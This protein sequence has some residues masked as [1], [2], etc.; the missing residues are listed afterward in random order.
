[1]SFRKATAA[2]AAALLLGSGLGLLS[3][4][5]AQAVT[6][7]DIAGT[8]SSQL[9][10]NACGN[11]GAGYYVSG[12]GQHSSCYGGTT[13]HAWCA[14]FAG[15][16]WAQNGVKNLGVLNDL[17]NSFQTY[18][19]N[20]QGGLSS[21]PHVGDAVFFHPGG[22]SSSFTDYDHVAIV[23]AVNGN[24]TIDYVG[25]NQGGAPGAVTRNPGMPATVGAYEWSV[26]GTAVHLAG[27]A[28]PVL[29]NS[30]P[31]APNT[32]PALGNKGSIIAS[33][34]N[35]VT[36][37]RD[38]GS[39]HV[40]ITY[41]PVGGGW[42]TADLTAMT[43]GA[44]AGGGAPAAFLQGN[45]TLGVITAD[46]ANGH[47]RVTYQPS[48]GGWQTTDLTSSF[49]AP[50]SDG[51]VSTQIDGSGTL[52]VFTRNSSNGHPNLTYL[53]TSGGWQNFDL[54]DNVGTPVSGGGAPAAF[55]QGNGTLGV[56]T[57][58]AANGHLR[59]TY[60]PSGSGW[61]TSDLTSS[62][63]APVSDGQVGA[64]VDGSGTL[65]IFSRNSSNG[66]PN[67]TYLPTSGGWQNFDLTNSVG[68]PVSGG[69]APAPFLQSNG[70]LG[71]VTADAANGHLRI[72]YKPTGSGWQTS[73]LTSSFGA[74]TSDGN[75]SSV[76]AGDG[77]LSLYSRNAGNGHLN[78][79]YL[80]ASGAWG[81]TDMAYQAGTPSLG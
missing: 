77:T 67:L 47:L 21:T 78:L 25:G 6:G 40:Q 29:S 11:G 5:A 50:V 26:K 60:K 31:T 27:Y 58:D 62:F 57:A 12:T 22:Y 20:N 7:S 75:V 73:D 52:S 81:T 56:V 65:S 13:A 54:T 4:P 30:A 59:L 2:G 10:R 43:G 24:G 28:S 8:A 51:D 55:L 74:A 19:N 18:A 23:T 35:Q 63:G 42:A 1:M 66:H 46:A 79:A 68:T 38:A 70:T 15:W 34:G 53:P 69:G 64:I 76:I 41:L 48:G 9:D 61:Q 72:T 39:G 14:D 16:V 17:A 32:K 37:T 44:A 36:F 49:G 71:V 33:D 45:G 3:A 80:P